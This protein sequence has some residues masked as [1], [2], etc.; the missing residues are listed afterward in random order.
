MHLACPAQADS[1]SLKLC[2]SQRIVLPEGYSG[3]ARLKGFWDIVVDSLI[4]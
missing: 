1:G 3:R 2:Q 4:H